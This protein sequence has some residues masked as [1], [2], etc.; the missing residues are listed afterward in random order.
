MDSSSLLFV[1]SLTAILAAGLV[2]PIAVYSWKMI[3][4]TLPAFAK[5]GKQLRVN[6]NKY[7]DATF[8]IVALTAWI[9]LT[10]QS[11]HSYDSFNSFPD[12]RYADNILYNI[13]QNGEIKT[14]LYRFDPIMLALTPLYVIWHDPRILLILQSTGLAI[15]LLPIYWSA[16]K[17]VGR[18]LALGVA[19]AYVTHPSVQA[20][21]LPMFAEI[22]LAVPILS[23]AVFF[24]LRR[25]YRPFLACL[26]VSL[27]VKQEMMLTAVGFGGFILLFQGKRKL[28]LVLGAMGLAS[29]IL[30]VQ[31]VYPALAGVPYPHFAGG[32]FSYLG[33]T[34]DQVLRTLVQNPQLALSEISTPDK[35]SF[36]LKL[37]TPLTWLPLLG[38]DVLLIS[39]PA[40]AYTLLSREAN[41]FN[42]NQ[43]T[44]LP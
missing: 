17:I 44:R 36:V 32:R 27:L 21:N 5:M 18:P 40:W 19:L 39:F 11:I 14:Y 10:A 1:T 25:N 16:R 34:L 38:L 13:L 23:F 35:M 2:Y 12:M 29:A 33:T 7:L 30:F 15:S 8:G 41:Q 20:L 4:S 26:V 22:K 37:M 31:F 9:G 3:Q 24:L 28:G 42:P 6:Q 43:Y